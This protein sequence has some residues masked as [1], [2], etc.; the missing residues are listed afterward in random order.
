[1]FNG[2]RQDCQC[3]LSCALSH[4][5]LLPPPPPTSGCP[6]RHRRRLTAALSLITGELLRV[7]LI[8]RRVKAAHVSDS[9]GPSR[10]TH[11]SPSQPHDSPFHSTA[12]STKLSFTGLLMNGDARG[13]FRRGGCGD[14][15]VRLGW[16]GE[17]TFTEI[18]GYFGMWL[19][20]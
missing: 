4:S 6:G 9:E 10:M 15:R 1:M 18:C 3:G 12:L 16:V 13:L 8:T 11:L 19:N 17:R 20:W 7:A 5:E 14:R 2:C